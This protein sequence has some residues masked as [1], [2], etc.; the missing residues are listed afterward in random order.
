M[1]SFLVY[2]LPGELRFDF[3]RPRGIIVKGDFTRLIPRSPTVACIGD[4]VSSFCTRAN[5]GW[6]ILVVAVDGVTRRR[7]SV[8]PPGLRGFRTVHVRNPRGTVSR[9]AARAVCDALSGM[10]G[11]RVALN[12]DGEEDMLALA[13]IACSPLGGHVIYGVPGRGAAIIRVTRLS[14]LD[15]Q[16]RLLLL[17]PGI[18]V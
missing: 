1:V 17:R 7:E 10:L 5:S 11:E 6:D 13:A 16:T 4:V 14:R 18:R 8:E 12:V 9:A 3:A 15:A 2:T